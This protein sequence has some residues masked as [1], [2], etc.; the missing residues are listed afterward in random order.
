MKFILPGSVRKQLSKIGIPHTFGAQMENW[1]YGKRYKSNDDIIYCQDG[2]VISVRRKA[3]WIWRKNE[4][5]DN[6]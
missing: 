1:A 2:E 5:G 3:T 4:G 6:F